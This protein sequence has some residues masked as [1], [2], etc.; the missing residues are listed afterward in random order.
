MLF[1][2]YSVLGYSESFALAEVWFDQGLGF[3]YLW[4][5]DLFVNLCKWTEPIAA[6]TMRDF[7]DVPGR[8]FV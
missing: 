2:R 1:F 4:E 5:E 3:W 8:Q 6:S 7:E